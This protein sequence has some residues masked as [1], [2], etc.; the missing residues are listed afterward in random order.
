MLELAESW[1]ALRTRELARPDLD[2]FI[3]GQGIL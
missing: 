3:A 1:M 2:A